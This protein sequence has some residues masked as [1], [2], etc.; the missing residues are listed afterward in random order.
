MTRPITAEQFRLLLAALGSQGR[1]DVRWAESVLPPID[2][3]QF[4]MDAIFVICNSGMK[5]TVASGIFERCRAALTSPTPVPVIEVFK[6]KGKAAAI[7]QIWRERSKL[8]AGYT[9][10][11]DKLA[12]LENLPWIGS[13]TKFHLAKNFG[14]QVAKPDVHLQRMADREGCTAQELCERPA[15]STGYRVATID[16]ILW[17]AAANGLLNS[18]TGAFLVI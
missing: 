4:A 8:L 12:F 18:K 3:D 1:E 15:A 11:V 17:R 7:E 10:A 16:T 9:A 6:H 2:P 5:N 13:I 14:V